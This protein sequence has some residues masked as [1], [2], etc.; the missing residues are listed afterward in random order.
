MKYFDPHIHMLAR[1][2]DDYE[3]MAAAGIIG[4]V[5]PAFWL[6]QPRTQAASF[7]DYFNSLI[8]WESFRASQFGIRHYCTIGINPKEVNN[9]PM[10]EEV[11]KFLPRYCAKDNVVAIGEIGYDDITDAEDRF[12]AE[13]LELAKALNLP[14]LVHTPHRDKKTGTERTLALVKEVGINPELVL[15]DHLNEVT[16]PLVLDSG[17]WRGH[18]VYPDT[19]MSETRMVALLQQY[20]LE[21]MVVNSAADWGKSDP[22]KVPKT[23]QAM[24]DAGFSEADIERVLFTNPIQYY[25]QSGRISVDEVL[26]PVAIDQQKLWEDNSVLRG[27]TPI[28]K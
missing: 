19:K 4:V 7:I 12:F 22:L 13:Q 11:M 23:G 18:S 25:A 8:G 27:Q 26:V 17:C 2:T 24:L 20:G 9:I 1:T 6:G 16:L 28:V 5:E 21:K 15:V 10:A 14:A 3:R